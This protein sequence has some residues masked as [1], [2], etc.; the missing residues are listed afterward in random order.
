MMEIDSRVLVS[1]APHVLD[2]AGPGDPVWG[3]ALALGDCGVDICTTWRSSACR[4]TSAARWEV[5]F[6]D[7]GW[8]S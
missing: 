3:D 6:D 7:R 8:I 1:T 4:V 2:A 5:S